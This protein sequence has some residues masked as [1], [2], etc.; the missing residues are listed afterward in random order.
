SARG[1]LER[2]FGAGRGGWMIAGRRSYLDLVSL[3]MEKL[4]GGSDVHVP[5]DFHDVTGRFDLPLGERS[6]LE[7]SAIW[8]QD[9]VRG[10]IP[11][12]P[13]AS[14]SRWGNAAGRVTFDTPWYGLRIRHTVGGSHFYARGLK[15]PEGE[16]AEVLQSFTFPWEDPT[17]STLDVVVLEGEIG[18]FQSSPSRAWGSGYAMIAQRQRYRGPAPTPYPGR[19]T[20]RHVALDQ[21]MGLLA[22][23]AERRWRLA[24][25]LEIETGVRAETGSAV[26]DAGRLRLAPRVSARRQ[27]GGSAAYVSAGWA[28]SWQ[29]TQTVSPVGLSVGPR[30]HP[31]DLW[32][33]AGDSLPAL[34]SDVVTLGGEGWLGSA[35]L[36]SATGWA[37]S[38]ENFL[39]TPPDKGPVVDDPIFV[40][41][42]NKAR[43]IELSLRRLVGTWT[44]SVSYTLSRSTVEANGRSFPAASDRRHGLD[45]AVIGEIGRGVRAGTA[46]AWST[47]APYTRFFPA[48]LDCDFALESCRITESA[49]VEEPNAERTGAYASVDALV[50]WTTS[51]EGW[52]LTVYGQIRN[53]LGR[54]NAITYLGSRLECG[55]EPVGGPCPDAFRVVDEF[56]RGLPRLPTVGVRV[57]F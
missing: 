19:T 9:A 56:D 42:A 2:G 36:V 27:L 18:P 29:Y 31:S 57:S 32:I 5:Y 48:T 34:R 53:L 16:L 43:G 20:L 6:A 23:W 21:E 54:R 37:R 40:E 49:R 12:E 35:W 55:S 52:D 25:H 24:E 41:G 38:T 46:L 51:R 8:Q 10:E 26:Q 28:R 15:D 4:G 47:G 14:R 39:V 50:E 33:L 7:A 45:A 17:R 22:A 44:G 1:A 30:L 3:V 13:D 11:A